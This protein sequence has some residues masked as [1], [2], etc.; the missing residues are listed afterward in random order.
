MADKENILTKTDD[1]ITWFLPKVEKFPRN[2]KFLIGDRVVQLQLDLLENLI[3]A[4]YQKQKLPPLRSANITI[5]KLRRLMKICTLMNFL[6][7]SQLEFAT[8]S[9][10]EIGGMVGGWVRQQEARHA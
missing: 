3:E 10:N 5:E 9:L 4:Y 2:Y 7:P 6:S 8:R 1:F